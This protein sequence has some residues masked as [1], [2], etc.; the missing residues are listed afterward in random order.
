[1]EIP[2]PHETLTDRELTTLRVL[3]YITI[4]LFSCNLVFLTAN[5]MRYLIPLK[6]GSPLITLFYGLAALLTVARIVEC[7]YFVMMDN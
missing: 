4:L 2:L 3:G 1:M 6:L 5:I 7:S